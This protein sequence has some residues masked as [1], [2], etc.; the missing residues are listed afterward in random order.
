MCPYT[1]EATSGKVL[2]SVKISNSGV[3][4]PFRG[5]LT[6]TT[7]NI[8][9]LLTCSKGDR[10]CPDKPQYCGET[11]KSGEERFSKHRNTVTQL[12]YDNT[13]LPVGDHF[14]QPGHSV[15]NMVFTSIEK[16][17]SDNIFVRKVRERQLINNL[18]LINNGLNK[19]L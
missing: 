1:G 9:Y 5:K 14:R 2:K 15:A 6:C 18:D 16:I 3:D 12:C 19:K 4:M 8:L 17:F 10:A 11:G 7:K 13:T